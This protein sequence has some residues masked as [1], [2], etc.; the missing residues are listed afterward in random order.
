MRIHIIVLVALL[1]ALPALA[2]VGYTEAIAACERAAAEMAN[3]AAE[4]RNEAMAEKRADAIRDKSRDLSRKFIDASQSLR[5]E[6]ERLDTNP[7]ENAAA[8]KRVAE[9]EKRLEA[10]RERLKVLTAN[11]ADNQTMLNAV[12]SGFLERTA[13]EVSAA[14]QEVGKAL[15]AASASLGTAKVGAVELR[16]LRV[17]QGKL[18]LFV[19]T[20]DREQELVQGKQV[21]VPGLPITLRAEV[22]DQNRTRL[23]EQKARHLLPAGTEFVETDGKCKAGRQFAYEN[24]RVGKTSWTVKETFKW[25]TESDSKEQLRGFAQRASDPCAENDVVELHTKGPAVQRL[26]LRL[27]GKATWKRQSQLKGGNREETVEP[28][29]GTVDAEL[30]LGVWPK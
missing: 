18:R 29:D 8:L 12:R 19:V 9:A 16:E 28:Q 24:S 27:A 23:E 21:F 13:N 10:A 15:D 5:A 17:N 14:T 20:G 2:Q 30:V 3:L 25:E 22:R 26:V 7:K 6:R 1:S 4:A 11:L